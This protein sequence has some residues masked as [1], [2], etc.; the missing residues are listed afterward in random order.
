MSPAKTKSA[1]SMNDK[2]V[3]VVESPAKA[4]TI[5]RYLG[6]GYKVLASYGHVRDLAH[7]TGSVDPEHDFAMVWASEPGATKHVD[8]ILKAVRDA[9]T[10]ILA[11]DPDREGEAI[12]WHVSQIIEKKCG[13][14][15]PPMQRVVFH[16][17]TKNVVRKAMEEPRTIDTLLVDAYLARRALDY[18]VGYSL[19]PI[20]WQKLPGARSAGR[21]QSVALRLVVEREQDIEKFK[22]QE[23]WSLDGLFRTAS[24]AS[25]KARLIVH[26]EDKLAKFAI[27]DAATAKALEAEV[28]ARRYA[29]ASLEKK[30]VRRFPTPPFTTSTLQQE[31]SRKLGFGVSR[32]MRTAQRLYE[33]IK[34]NGESVGLITYMRTDSVNLSQESLKEMRKFIQEGFGADYLPKEARIYK[35]KTRNAQEAHEAIR[36]TSV[37]RQ[38]E[39]M[40]AFLDEDQ[41]KLYHLIWQRALA[42]QMENAVFDQVTADI[43]DASGMTV[44]RAVGTTQVFDGFL[45]LYQE[46]RDEGDKDESAED[47]DGTK[48]PLLQKGEALTL[49]QTLPEQHFTQ[50]P[51]RFTEASLVKRLEELGIG[52]PSTYAPVMQILKDR[53]YVTVERKQ[54]IP[55]I[56]GR[57]V[58]AFLAHFCSKYVQYDFTANLEEQ[59][60][61]IAEGSLGWKT[62]MNDFW[63]D[64]SKAI[65]EMK[66]IATPDVMTMLETELDDF[67]FGDGKDGEGARNARICPKCGTGHMGLKLSRFGAF[68]GCSNY[69]DCTY[70]VPLGDD[71]ERAIQ[72]AVEPVELGVDPSDESVLS[73]RRGPY[74]FYV[75]VD[76]KEP[77][78]EEAPAEAEGEKPKKRS[79]KKKVSNVKRIGLPE[80]MDPA[81]VTL[82]VAL[83]LKALP[84]VLGQHEGQDVSVNLG[85]FGPFVKWGTTLASVPKGADFMTLPLEEAVHLITE[86][87]AKPATA[88]RGGRK[89]ATAEGEAETVSIA[90]PPRKKTAEK[91]SKAPAPRTRKKKE[92]EA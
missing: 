73:L 32:T 60:D 12:A 49:A 14:A 3:V 42:S 7:K 63:A 89:A 64:F 44:F 8:A 39:E 15:T 5:E 68:L 37:F 30:Q 36:P 54:F 19:S 65:G 38:P 70:R 69:P 72:M 79:R 13:K 26:Q 83:Q 28:Q 20:L 58:I 21:V 2:T 66:T 31:A 33:G 86:R 80:T 88:R 29:V 45:R 59:L 61:E 67:L 4:S 6:K 71:G 48:L 11:T 87:L 22:S 1:S 52:R 35:T 47:G 27:P 78:A 74:G 41:L 18:L 76:F 43:A 50:P 90:K 82:E 23:F 16:E 24:K 75:Q 91:A 51:P 57:I 34:I 25:V 10:L 40:A 53:E 17:I 55:S 81:N 56:R 92:E 84:K 62:V 85:R 9:G 77:P 46:S